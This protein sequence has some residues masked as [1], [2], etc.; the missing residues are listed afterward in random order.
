M[1]GWKHSH[2]LSMH[3]M[4]PKGYIKFTDNSNVCF[5]SFNNSNK[6]IQQSFV[7]IVLSLRNFKDI[8]KGSSKERREYISK[9]N[10][11]VTHRT[12]QLIEYTILHKIHRNVKYNYKQFIYNL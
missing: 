7:V 8:N 6:R 4:T 11:N 9:N 2:L 10:Y 5:V 3:S 12:R 1:S